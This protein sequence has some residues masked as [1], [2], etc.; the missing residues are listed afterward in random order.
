MV[1]SMSESP[2]FLRPGRLIFW[3]AILC[4]AGYAFLIEPVWVEVTHHPVGNGSSGD[5]IRVAQLSDLHLQNIG[6][7]EENTLEAVR[8]IA[9]DVIL[10]TGDVVDRPDTLPV[11]DVYLAKLDAP[12]KLAVLGNWEYWG[13]VDQ[14]ELRKIYARHG[15]RLLINECVQVAVGKQTLRVA[16]LDDF[17]AG[18]PDA[19]KLDPV[20][21]GNGRDLILIQHAPGFF[22]VEM[23]RTGFPKPALALSGHTHGGQVSLFGYAFWTPP[24]SGRYNRGWYDTEWGKLYVSRGV[25]TSIT[26][27]RFA[28]RPEIP[29]FEL[30]P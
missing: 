7:T 12:V 21:V 8:E 11:L 18:R 23:P 17:T 6:R 19:G 30:Q 3:G 13:S 9:P 4:L 28:S 27:V 5:H 15:V 25:G 26:K 20:C 24:G 22:E 1:G 16:G 14:A 10:L 2:K 29:V